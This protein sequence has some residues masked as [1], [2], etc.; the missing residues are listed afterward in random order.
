M[1]EYDRDVKVMLYARAGIQETWLVDLQNE[2]VD[3]F[4]GPT[5]A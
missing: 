4:T 2:C 3:L 1:C 5:H